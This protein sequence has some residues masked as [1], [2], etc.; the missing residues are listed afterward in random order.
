[1]LKKKPDTFNYIKMKNFK[2]STHAMKRAKKQEK[3]ANM[4]TQFTKENTQVLKI[5]TNTC[6]TMLITHKY[7]N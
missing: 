1:M 3:W 7:E 2:S 4:T 5:H 6:S